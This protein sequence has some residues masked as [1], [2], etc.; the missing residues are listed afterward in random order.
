MEQ[1]RF[2]KW[3]V[4]L[5]LLVWVSAPALIY[6]PGVQIDPVLIYQVQVSCD[7]LEASLR[8]TYGTIS[9]SD[10]DYYVKTY[11]ANYFLHQLSNAP[12]LRP[13]SNVVVGSNNTANTSHSIII[14]NDNIVLGTGNYVFSQNFNSV[15]AGATGNDLVLD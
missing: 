7:R 14:G 1:M 13:Y 2:S 8:A 9:E 15:A 6:I 3:W 4:T 10:I 11:A 12:P 5:A